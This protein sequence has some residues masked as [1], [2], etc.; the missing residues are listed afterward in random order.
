MEKLALTS[1]WKNKNVL[2]TG[3]TGFKGSWLT[4]WLH[5]KKANIFGYALDN[6]NENSLYQ[7][8][9]KKIKIVEKKQDIRNAV[10]FQK[11][12]NHSNPDIIF[13]LAAQ[14][15]VRDSYLHPI[16]T[17][18]TNTFG[19]INLLASLKKIKK[20]C[21][22]IFIT[23]D[24][25][26]KNTSNK[27]YAFIET[28]Q[29]GG[30]DPYSSS[31]A[32][33]ELAIYSWAKGLYHNKNFK[34]GVARAGNVL[35]GGDWANDRLMPDIINALEKNKIIT[36]RNPNATRP[37]QHVLDCLSGYM[38]LAEYMYKNNKSKFDIYNFGPNKKNIKNVQTLLKVVLKYW[39]GNWRSI[40][41]ND[42][43]FEAENLVLS[44][45]KAKKKL[46][47]KPLLNLNKSVELTIDW[48][49]KK[50]TGF[51]KTLEQINYYE[52]IARKKKL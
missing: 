43:K 52:N 1:F 47:W 51:E 11:Y 40:Y 13:H 8:L 25:V 5:K 41:M 45:L 31:K 10:I 6:K 28:D 15:L 20:K 42:N 21:V 4:C 23:T 16:E 7:L 48:Y 35:G 18:Q 19:T 17:W 24:K 9:K 38:C 34:I 39:Q 2:I 44:N 49:L 14:P 37:W 27:N 36:I 50:N 30:V 22:I 46:K 26:Y 32:A 33:S 29:L 12:I 3:H